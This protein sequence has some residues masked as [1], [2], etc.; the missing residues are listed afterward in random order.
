MKDIKIFYINLDS[1]NDRNEH[2]KKILEG[3]N[4]ER[5]SAIEDEDGYIGC[6]K[7]HI[8]CIEIA[9]LRKYQKVIILEDDFIF[10]KNN[11]FDNII[12]PNFEYDILLLCNLIMKK[13]K[14][15]NTFSRVY[16][17]QWTSGHL[18]NNTFYNPL[19]NNL[20]EGIESRIKEGKKISNNLDFYWNKL[21]N[22]YKCIC[23]NETFATQKEGYSDIKKEHMNRYNIY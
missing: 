10:K 21:F 13:E 11:S 2:M 1:R 7:S 22:D 18:V 9:R 15:N 3:Y 6:A 5:V 14:I 20:Q 12:I 19:I 4:F 16:Q 17:T 8:K 23:H